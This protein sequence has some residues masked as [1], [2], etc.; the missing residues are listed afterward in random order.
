MELDG[1]DNGYYELTVYDTDSGSR[2]QLAKTSLSILEDCEFASSDKSYFGVNM[3]MHR[4]NEVGW[5]TELIKNAYAIGAMNIRDGKEWPDVEQTKGSYNFSFANVKS[6]MTEKGMDYLY[7]AGFTNKYYDDNMSPYTNDGR[8][9]YANYIKAAYETYKNSF[10]KNV[11][12]YNEW[13]AQGGRNG[14]PAGGTPEYFYELIKTTY[15]TIKDSKYPDRKL[16]VNLG[17]ED[18]NNS[19]YDLGVCNYMDVASVHFYPVHFDKSYPSDLPENGTAE[20]VTDYRVELDKH[21]PDKHIPI[22]VTETGYSTT[23][24][25]NGVTEATQGK[26]LP[27]TYLEYISHGA[28]K[29]YWYDL[30]DDG[31]VD[32]ADRG[33]THEYHFGIMRAVGNSMGGY[34]PKPAYVAFGVMTRALNGLE[35]KSVTKDNGYYDYVFSDGERTVHAMYALTPVAAEFETDK[36]VT[37]TDLMGRKK[38]VSPANGK[39]RLDLTDE[40]IYVG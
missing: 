36:A 32:Y 39:I 18:F 33:A 27:R 5:K 19:L 21:S 6:F 35:F 8:Q 12:V 25:E 30:L 17:S 15:E 1:L 9:G 38:T 11:D 13:F 2:V 40:I 3:H 14:S 37:V 31:V 24:R 16:F 28:E 10:I 23:I 7:Q 29:V 26:Y 34:T 20:H 22:W 4:N